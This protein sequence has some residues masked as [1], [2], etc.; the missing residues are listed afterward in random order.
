MSA[1]V[2]YSQ[3]SRVIVRERT[4]ANTPEMGR[5]A[6]P[7]AVRRDSVRFATAMPDRHRVECRERRDQP[8]G[9]RRDP[10]R[11]LFGIADRAGALITRRMVEAHLAEWASLEDCRCNAPCGLAR[12]VTPSTVWWCAA[13]WQASI[14][15]SWL[16]RKTLESPKTFHVLRAFEAS[17]LHSG[18]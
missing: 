9:G 5:V 3:L 15:H 1:G 4:A 10:A 6:V 16:G 8:R 13:L 14:A 18:R 7:V 2:R 12:K 11:H 17:R